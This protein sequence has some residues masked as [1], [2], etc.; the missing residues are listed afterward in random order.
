MSDKIN[1]IINAIDNMYYDEIEEI[2][3]FDNY[4]KIK[5]YY[6]NIN[7]IL[8]CDKYAGSLICYIGLGSI[9]YTYNNLDFL[10]ISNLAPTFRFFENDDDE[11]N[12]YITNIQKQQISFKNIDT[13]NIDLTIEELDALI[14]AILTNAD[15]D[16]KKIKLII[17]LYNKIKKED[18]KINL[19]IKKCYKYTGGTINYRKNSLSICLNN[20]INY[21]E[22][23]IIKKYNDNDE[24]ILLYFDNDD[25]EI[26]LL[27]EINIDNSLQF[28]TKSN[29]QFEKTIN[30]NFNNKELSELI[31]SNIK[32][33]ID[34]D[35][36]DIYKDTSNSISS[37]LRSKQRRKYWNFINKLKFH[38]K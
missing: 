38:I 26:I 17:N 7:Y 22:K 2:A 27:Y 19:D 21:S 33:N 1:N 9:I 24:I 16:Y 20:K 12:E 25:D 30:N 5:L 29:S 10:K 15:Y 11:K 18:F 23:L 6:E 34:S 28:H 13:K 14:P 31:K 4:I 36:I 37:E 3:N 35:I 32:K 8:C